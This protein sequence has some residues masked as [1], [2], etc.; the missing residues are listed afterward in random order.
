LCH[1]AQVHGAWAGIRLQAAGVGEARAAY[2]PTLNGSLS[3]VHDRTAYPGA[4]SASSS[5]NSNM[6]SLSFSWRLFD[7]GGRAAGQRGATALLDA[8]LANR[9]AV[10]QKTLAAA[11]GAYFDAQTAQAT[12]RMRREYQALAQDTVAAT[13]RRAQRG[14][15]SHS[16]TLQAESA[17]AKAALGASRAGGE[18]DKA[19]AVLIYILGLP[20]GAGVTVGD[21][22]DAPASG[23]REDL[24]AWL[25][26]AQV[27]HPAI[28][29]AQAQ[30]AAARERVA[31]ARSEGRP[32]MDLTA[33]FYQ[34][35]RPNQGL[36]PASTR[37]TLV[38]V[39]LNIPLFD[40]YA[41]GY[42]VR[43]AQAQVA[44]KEAEAQETQQQTLMELVKAHAEADMALANLA[45]SRTWLDAAQEAQASVQRK[46]GLG[47]ADIL[48]MLAT[49]SALL[50]AQQERI[51]CQGEWRAARLR[52]LA[53][54]GVLGREA[55]A[56]R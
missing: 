38:G 3:R 20:A 50:E 48:E 18:D 29:A 42:K 54:A 40:G 23:L 56:G 33:N 45:A 53:S 27:R 41:R 51:R 12:A 47:A 14:L 13:R 37:E 25:A 34:N 44:Q 8:A 21:D 32:S 46:F 9:D 11:V 6:G 16:D 19:R 2:L 49:Q 30:V 15:G 4:A 10:L 7:F 5:L 31:V 39:S 35:G 43:G 55:I 1:N 28:V 36:S 26:Q 24:Q 22:A 17:L 52:L